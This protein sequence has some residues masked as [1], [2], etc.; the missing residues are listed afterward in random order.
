VGKAVLN[1][2]V[3]V[4][5]ERP[6]VLEDL[7][8]LYLVVQLLLVDLESLVVLV[9]LQNLNVVQSIFLKN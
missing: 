9:V 8:L 5:L 3:L 1:L 4:V 6:V 2:A 7:P